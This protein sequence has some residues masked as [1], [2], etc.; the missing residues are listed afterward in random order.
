MVNYRHNMKKKKIRP[1]YLFFLKNKKA[2]KYVY[3]YFWMRI[4]KSGKFSS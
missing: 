2:F 1:H 3:A 4:M